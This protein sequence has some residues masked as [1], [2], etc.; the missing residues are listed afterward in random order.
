MRSEIR[1]KFE[2][3]YPRD[4]ILF[5]TPRHAIL[6]QNNQK[7][8]D[9]DLTDAK[10]LIEALDTFFSHRPQEYTEWEEA[11]AQFRDKVPRI[12]RGLADLIQ[13]E[14]DSNA[15][16]ARA[17]RTFHEKC[18]QSINPNLSDAAVEEMLIQHSFNQ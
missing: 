9:A 17:F 12:G 10:Q 8:L 14:R 1:S 18:C 2:S 4:N 5:Q 15:H 11:V 16:F 13:G 7:K 3:G 6:W